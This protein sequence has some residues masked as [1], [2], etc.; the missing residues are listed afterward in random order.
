MMFAFELPSTHVLLISGKHTKHLFE[1]SLYDET[2]I[3]ILSYF[4][5][6]VKN[7]IV[8]NNNTIQT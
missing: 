5:Y 8:D 6:I 1:D 3:V 7:K 4:Q 2:Q